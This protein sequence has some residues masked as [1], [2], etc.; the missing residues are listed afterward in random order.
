[1]TGIG[2]GDDFDPGPFPPD[3]FKQPST[4]LSVD[5][6]SM[7]TAWYG[8]PAPLKTGFQSLRSG[9]NVLLFVVTGI[10]RPM[11]DF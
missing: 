2:L 1:M 5:P 7:K 4:T 3:C 8:T 10:Q 6:S 9:F 11:S